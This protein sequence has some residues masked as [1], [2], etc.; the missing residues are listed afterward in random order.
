MASDHAV[1]AR[2]RY[3][4]W[5]QCNVD[6]AWRVAAACTDAQLRLM[7]PCAESL[8]AAG[9]RTCVSGTRCRRALLS[10]AASAC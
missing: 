10:D 1:P 7:A 5:L 6:G 9:T 4:P 2:T 3:A 8:T